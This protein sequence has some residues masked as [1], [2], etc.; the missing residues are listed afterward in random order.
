[1]L[2]DSYWISY[3]YTFAEF[4]S[5]IKNALLTQTRNNASIYAVN[6]FIRGRPWTIAVDD[7]L[8]M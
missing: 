5:L 3:M 4:P 2:E 7:Y 1:M 6:Y 8:L